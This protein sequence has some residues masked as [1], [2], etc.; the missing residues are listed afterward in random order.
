MFLVRRQDLTVHLP[1]L[2]L[3]TI[4]S[5][6]SVQKKM[7]RKERKKAGLLNK[8]KKIVPVAPAR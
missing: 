4:E 3:V 7:N 5:V 2:Q 1:L 6:I 8:D